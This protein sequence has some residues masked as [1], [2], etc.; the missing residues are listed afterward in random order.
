MTSATGASVYDNVQADG[1]AKEE[2]LNEV[3]ERYA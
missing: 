2:Y 1:N 3:V